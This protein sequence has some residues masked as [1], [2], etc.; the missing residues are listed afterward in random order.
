MHHNTIDHIREELILSTL[1]TDLKPGLILSLIAGDH[2]DQWPDPVKRKAWSFLFGKSFSVSIVPLITQGKAVIFIGIGFET[3]APTIASSI[4]EAQEQ[5]LTNYYVLSLNKLCPPIIKTLLE[6]GELKLNGIIA[7][8]HVSAIIGSR[9]YTFIPED[10]GV[11]CAI[12][13][14]EPL[15]ILLAIY[16][17]VNQ[18]QTEDYRVEIA[19]RRGVKPEGNTQAQKLLDEVFEVSESRWRGIGAVPAS[20]LKIKNKYRRYDA[21]E[22]FSITTRPSE[23]PKD[24]IC[25][26]ILRGVSTPLDCRLYRLKC[27]PEHPVG[28]CMVSS[29]GSCAT[30]YH[31]GNRDER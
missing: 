11:A 21:E 22:S 18:I 7:P 15:D 20:G 12:S 31:Y 5:K 25:G 4:L 17:L 19:Y 2:I 30:Y 16:R 24:C 6:R 1:R 23:E 28:P 29:E 13:G 10:F 8:G 27:T 14:F 9:P 26:D 3:T